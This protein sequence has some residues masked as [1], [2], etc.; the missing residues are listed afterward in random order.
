[1]VLGNVIGRCQ[2]QGPSSTAGAAT[3]CGRS[4]RAWDALSCSDHISSCRT[5][6]WISGSRECPAAAINGPH[7]GGAPKSNMASNPAG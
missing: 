1:M 2:L 7:W 5:R 6:S 3:A 4:A